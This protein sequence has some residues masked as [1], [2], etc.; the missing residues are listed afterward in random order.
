MD[1]LPIEYQEF[2]K[3]WSD[4]D[5]KSDVRE[6]WIPVLMNIVIS[7]LFSIIGLIIGGAILGSLFGL[8]IF[9]PNIAVM[10]RRFHDTGRSG[11]YWLWL[12]LPFIGWI[13]VIL[14]LIQ[15]SK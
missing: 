9:V 14:A 6:Y 1:K 2:W 8:A 3:R 15:P 4:F 5:G 12:F 11:W 7:I 13:I 10:I